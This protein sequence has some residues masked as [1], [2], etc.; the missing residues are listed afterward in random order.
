M[1]K[2]YMAFVRFS[3][4]VSFV[5]EI[6]PAIDTRQEATEGGLMV[7]PVNF[8]EAEIDELESDD[9]TAWLPMMVW[10]ILALSAKNRPKQQPGQYAN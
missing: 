4:G 8:T 10:Q 9:R 5:Q 1:L 6:R 7:S 2:R 3:E